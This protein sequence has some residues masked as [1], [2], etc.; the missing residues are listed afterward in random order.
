MA[1][2]DPH[3]VK[4]QEVKTKLLFAASQLQGDRETQEDYFINFNDECFVV[5]DGVGGM[6]HGEVASQLAS[7]TAIWAFKHIRQHPYYWEDKKLFMKRIFRSTNL[8]VWQKKREFGFE[9]G[10]ATT[11]LVCI[12]GEMRYWIGSVGDTRAYIMETY[13]MRELTTDDLDAQGRLTKAVGFQRLGLKAQFATG[14]LKAG[15]IMLLATDGVTKYLSHS[16]IE[17][18]LLHIGDTT[19][20]LSDGVMRLLKE[21]QKN[22]ST[23]NMTACMMKRVLK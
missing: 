8:A 6:P 1:I 5:A 2:V 15:G 23:D 9:E 4:F 22:G 20:S 18:V 14:V 10:L 17:D 11:L 7:E 13:L 3:F 16:E 21:A 12:M 19:E